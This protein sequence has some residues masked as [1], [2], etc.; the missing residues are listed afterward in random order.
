MLSRRIIFA[1]SSGILVLCLGT[2][3]HFLPTSK[4]SQWITLKD[5]SIWSHEYLLMWPYF[6][7]SIFLWILHNKIDPTKDCFL[8][9]FYGLIS[10]LILM[11]LL[12]LLYTLGNVNKHILII[13]IFLFVIV[14]VAAEVISYYTRTK[15]S[16]T[17][18]VLGILMS[19][20][21][22]AVVII[23]SY[24]SDNINNVLFESPD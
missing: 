6:L 20:V 16:K 12:F 21:T 7:S 11:P 15:P 9:R 22:L 5:E 10:G 23:F 13:D 1:I 17:K 14:V 24:T 18:T 2:A 19:L 8:S 4:N 3:L